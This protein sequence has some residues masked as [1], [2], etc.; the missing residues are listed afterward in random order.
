MNQNMLRQVKMVVNKLKRDYGLELHIWHPTSTVN[1]IET[2]KIV[3]TY[4]IHYIRKGVVLPK[5][6]SR[7]FAYAL[8]YIASGKN[9]VYG[10][11]FDS[12][13]RD[14]LIDVD[15]LPAE[16]ELTNND[17]FVFEGK[18]W[19]IRSIELSEHNQSYY[20][21]AQQVA[22]YDDVTPKYTIT[23]GTSHRI[24]GSYFLNGILNTRQAYCLHNGNYWL[25]YH[26]G[27]LNTWI[28]SEE[29]NV[30]GT[31]HWAKGDVTITG[32]YLPHGE[33]VGTVTVAAY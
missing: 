33:A 5:N 11:Y 22:S 6:F 4:D 7:D 3:R 14:L 31:F 13:R 23:G 30:L 16:F 32:S 17:F 2:G 10:G 20:V 28:I 24:N 19:E 12:A 9:F 29:K 18:R 27:A 25:W 26:P 8:S 21:V 1:N 15:D